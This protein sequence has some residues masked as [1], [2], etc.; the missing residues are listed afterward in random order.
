MQQALAA[1]GAER[2][3]LT[4]KLAYGEAEAARLLSLRHHQLR[5]ERRRGRIKASKGPGK[6]ILYSPENLIEYLLSRP[7]TPSADG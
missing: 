3:K 6:M 5:D 7:Y 1:L 4:G 2:A